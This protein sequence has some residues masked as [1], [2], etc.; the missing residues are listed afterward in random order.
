MKNGCGESRRSGVGRD[1]DRKRRQA[2]ERLADAYFSQVLRVDLQFETC[3]LWLSGILSVV[4]ISYR[5]YLF[6]SDPCQYVIKV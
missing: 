6:A 3:I 4:A 5:I 2:N 1:A